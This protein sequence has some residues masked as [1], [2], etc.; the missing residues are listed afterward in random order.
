[1]L[2]IACN[3][4]AGGFSLGFESS[5]IKILCHLE[6]TSL[7]GAK[8]FRNNRDIPL[9][10]DPSGLWE[11]TTNPYPEFNLY[12]VEP[13][14]LFGCGDKFFHLINRWLPPFVVYGGNGYRSSCRKEI[15]RMEA[16]ALAL[17]YSVTY[18]YL[19]SGHC[20]VT[21]V[22]SARIF[23]V[24]HKTVLSPEI[25]IQGALPTPENA[26][27]INTLS[28]LSGYPLRWKW[29]E[30]YSVAAK[31]VN[32]PLPGFGKWFGRMIQKSAWKGKACQSPKVFFY[33]NRKFPVIHERIDHVQ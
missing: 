27:G 30:R 15:R 6:N 24:L 32:Q 21:A 9:I 10:V 25:G 33:D 17:G 29:P 22:N 1:M 26:V 12:E 13:D 19:R 8:T 2:A 20:F 23:A 3:V 11:E 14:L 4:G 16:R 18:C 31:Q 5:G 7:K 28:R